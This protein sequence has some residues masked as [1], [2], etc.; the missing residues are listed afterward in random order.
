[1]PSPGP[2]LAAADSPVVELS[3]RVGVVALAAT[4]ALVT[5]ALL[6]RLGSAGRERRYRILE[7][8]WTPLMLA[9]LRDPAGVDLPKLRRRD[10][11]VV[12]ALWNRLHDTVRGSGRELLSEFA[13]RSG[14]EA[15]AMRL[16]ARKRS[17]DRVVAIAT[18]GNLR[19]RAA[20]PA[21]LE[22]A[23][24]RSF[25][26]RS[27]VARAL[28]RIDPIEGGIVVASLL[29]DWEDCHPA[30]YAAILEDADP[31]AATA[32]VASRAAAEPAVERQL[33]LVRV[34]ATLRHPGA[35]A[36][37][38]A[39]LGQAR[40]PELT[41]ACVAALARS[42]DPGDAE[43]V[44]PYLAHPESFVR[45]QAVSTLGRLRRPSDVWPIAGRLSDPDW[46]VR[47]RAAH[48]L[49]QFPRLSRRVVELLSAVHPDRFARDALRQ[50]LTETPPA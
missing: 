5:A 16:L 20:W 45:V 32:A 37:I 40:D 25:V 26:V 2:L 24:S 33:R 15:V 10:R 47:Y 3:I 12:L 18:L 31:A 27:R 6:A 8:R 34:L 49:A 9:A 39:I 28:V 23:T 19:A 38:R 4:G 1:M 50:V 21:L 43:L 13:R 42:R 48:A 44:R 46:W 36:A 29:A 30:T 17:S 11:S 35:V 22:L 14:F 7:A 41:A